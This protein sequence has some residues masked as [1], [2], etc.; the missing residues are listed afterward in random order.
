MQ[1]LRSVLDYLAEMN[2]RLD[3]EKDASPFRK[4]AYSKAHETIVAA[5]TLEGYEKMPG[6]GPSIRSDIAEIISTGKSSKLEELRRNGPPASVMELTR[7]R[8]VGPRKAIKLYEAG[9]S[10]MQD[11]E[12]AINSHRV[13][14]PKLIAAFYASITTHERIR[15]DQVDAATLPVIELIRQQTGVIECDR[16]GS[17]RRHRPD[18]RDIDILVCVSDLERVPRIVAAIAK[19]VGSKAK[20]EGPRKSYVDFAVAGEDRM[21]DLNFC[22]EQEY[23]CALLHFTGSKD[24]NVACR[25][26]ALKRGLT[27]NQYSLQHNV[28]NKHKYFNS[29]R[30]VLDFLDIDWVPPEC[31]DYHLPGKSAT[32]PPI[33][34][35]SEIIGDLHIHTKASDGSMTIVEVMKS[36]AKL[37]YVCAGISDH[38]QSSGNGV[39]QATAIER[40]SRIKAHRKF[41][42]VHA[43]AGV[44]L[45]IRANN[46]IDYDV[47]ALASFD[48]VILAVHAQPELRTFDRI[49]AAVKQIR[50]AH[51]K[52]PLA[53]AHPTSRLIGSRPEADM[54]WGQAMK[55]CA[56]YRVAIEINGQPARL[57]LPDSK[58]VVAKRF[59]CKFIVSSDSHGKQISAIDPAVMIARRA[60]L[61]RNDV[62][63]ASASSLKAWLKGSY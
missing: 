19:G 38:S 32:L 9:I 4:K 12:D 44:E 55:F 21:L 54:D 60:L 27:L 29:E 20:V 16:T 26:I 10:S 59:G 22:T 7:V 34:E 11:L 58:I 50:T 56:T 45:D 6:I 62:I 47:N 46:V 48:Y 49:S 5:G 25:N 51:P 24:F 41:G 8:N 30:A 18:V 2:F 57:D 40:A 61:T 23:G 31:R 1:A 52:L 36:A 13:V 14:D 28:T 3:L 42:S 37:G 53:W 15:R 17:F 35:S 63:N 43:F 39:D 33:I